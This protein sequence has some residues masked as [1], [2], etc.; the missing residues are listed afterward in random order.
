MMMNNLSSLYLSEEQ[1]YTWHLNWNPNQMQVYYSSV[2]QIAEVDNLTYWIINNE[3]TV[4]GFIDPNLF[5][6]QLIIPSKI[7]FNNIDYPV[8]MISTCV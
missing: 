2:L 6:G 4:V 5:T 1:T 7:T 8:T 3:A